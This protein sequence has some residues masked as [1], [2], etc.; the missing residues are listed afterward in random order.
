[1]VDM[2]G[3]VKFV[4][5]GGTAKR[6]ESFAYYVG[7]ELGIK[8]QTGVT[9]EDITQNANRYSMFKIGPVLSVTVRRR[10]TLYFSVYRQ[11]T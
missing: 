9:L 7:Q 10:A 1:M 5:V 4:C 6:M 11:N 3:D 2:F 8:L